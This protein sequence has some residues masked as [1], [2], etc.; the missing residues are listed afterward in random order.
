MGAYHRYEK[1]QRKLNFRREFFIKVHIFWEG[2]KILRNLH[3]RFVPCSNRQIYG[4]DLHQ[5]WKKG[6][7]TINLFKFLRKLI[8][9][10]TNLVFL[11]QVYLQEEKWY[12]QV[13]EK[14]IYIEPHFEAEKM[15]TH[16]ISIPLNFYY[17]STICESISPSLLTCYGSLKNTFP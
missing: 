1:R 9:L 5:Q 12:T 4:G 10:C 14:N 15:L 7:K 3:C 17:R 11:A 6:E 16:S 13:E 2:H 8:T